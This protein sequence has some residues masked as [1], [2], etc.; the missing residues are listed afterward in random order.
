MVMVA[1]AAIVPA[2]VAIVRG[3]RIGRLR[4]SYIGSGLCGGLHSGRPL[5]REKQSKCC[6]QQKKS[7]GTFHSQSP[8]R[9]KSPVGILNHRWR[10]KSRGI[11]L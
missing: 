10:R 5:G 2:M 3:C 6:G 1:L 9:M 7:Q 11:V 4:L 8:E